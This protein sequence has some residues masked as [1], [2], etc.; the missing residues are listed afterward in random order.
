MHDILNND[1]HS[2]YYTSAQAS[3]SVNSLNTELNSGKLS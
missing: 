3:Y 1:L 2:G